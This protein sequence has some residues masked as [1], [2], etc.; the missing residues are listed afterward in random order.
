MRY[1]GGKTKNA[2]AITDILKQHKGLKFFE[3]FCGGLNISVK[4]EGY[5]LHLND[6]N[7]KL[8]DMYKALI[9]GEFKLP[10]KP[11][12]KAEYDALRNSEDSH[13][14]TFVSFALSYGGK[15]W[16]GY[17]SYYDKR[18]EVGK[19]TRMAARSLT[20]KINKVKNAKWYSRDYK[21][22]NPKGFLIYCDPPYINTTGYKEGIDYDEFWNTM[23]EWSKDNIVYISEWEAPDDFEI[24]WAKDYKVQ[25]CKEQQCKVE[26]LFRL[27]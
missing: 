5:D 17:D 16:G 13:L 14:K 24:V 25:M 9:S 10:D 12:L 3:P 27:K 22:F 26:K 2:K 7:S 11:I 18:N 20:S 15:E 8:I 1:L 19:T 4:M 23:R 21:T 6:K